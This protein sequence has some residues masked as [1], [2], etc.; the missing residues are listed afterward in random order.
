MHFFILSFNI[1]YLPVTLK[2]YRNCSFLFDSSPFL[3][4]KNTWLCR[5]SYCMLMSFQ[6]I[7]EN[8]IA[9]DYI[10]RPNYYFSS[11][12]AFYCKDFSLALYAS[13]IK[14][15]VE[16]ESFCLIIGYLSEND[17]LI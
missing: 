15:A 8:Y 4:F 16:Y 12:S 14:E 11:Y 3:L 6:N 17:T 7:V 10:A 5:C 9:K 2:S 1:L 13:F